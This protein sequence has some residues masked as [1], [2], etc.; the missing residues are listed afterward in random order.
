M[1]LL[2]TGVLSAGAGRN[3]PAGF[4]YP[5]IP[6]APYARTR[7]HPASGEKPFARPATRP[8]RGGTRAC[9]RFG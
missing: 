6:G 7:F 5:F 8:G 3:Q 1:T 4:F 9:G 2:R